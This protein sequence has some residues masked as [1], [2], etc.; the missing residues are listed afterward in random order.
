MKE[1]K[2]GRLLLIDDDME[3][4]LLV[5]DYMELQNIVLEYRATGEEGLAALEKKHWDLILLDMMLPDIPGVEVLRRIRM[6]SGVPVIIFSAH[7]DETDRIVTLELGADDY[8]PKSFSSRELLAR[9]RAVLRRSAGNTGEG[10]EE[11][12]QVHGI[13]LNPR[14]FQVSFRGRP[15]E[16]TY[17]EFQLLQAMMREPGRI[18]SRETLLTL[19]A[20]KEWNKFDRSVDVHIS[21]LRKKLADATGANTH[22]RT[23]RGMGYVFIRQDEA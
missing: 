4:C 19:F 16:L 20:D 2:N 18:F 22:I 1:E 11:T 6:K 15:I 23:V 10:R 5:R 21:T 9:V 7:N 14:T 8:V 3:F 13:E 12:L 17:V